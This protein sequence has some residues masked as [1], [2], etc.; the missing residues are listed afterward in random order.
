M[1]MREL[2]KLVS[3]L[4]PLLTTAASVAGE[5]P[6]SIV[7]Q[8][9]PGVSGELKAQLRRYQNAR[10]ASFSGWL[11][12]RREVLIGTRFAD[13]N[14]V[15]RVAFPG[16]ARAQ[17]TFLDDRVVT[18]EP[19]PV[20]PAFAFGAD[21]GG[22]ENYQIFVQDARAGAPT[23]L[24]DGTSRNVLAGWS[25]SG[26][27]L[28]WSSNA[29]NG[30]DMDL[31]VAE[32]AD[33]KSRRRLKEVAGTWSIAD[34]SP[35][36][37][38]VAAV[39]YISANE[40]YVSTIDVATGATRTLNPRPAPGATT[41]SYDEVRFARDGRSLFWTTDLDSEFRRLAR[42][43]LET[44]RATVLTAA[45]PWDVEGYD[46]SD[47]GRTVVLVANEDGLSRL[48]VLDAADGR[49]RPAPALPAGQINGLK[50]RKGSQEFGFTLSSARAPGDVYS[51]DLASE[52]LER[53]TASETGGLDTSQFTEPELIHYPTF[54]GRPIP[55][56]V[57]RPGPKFAGPRPVLIDIHGGP[58]GQFRPGFLGRL[59]SLIDELGVALI[60]PNV[61][62]SSGY[63]KSYLKLDNGFAREDSVKDIGALLDWV[64]TQ[65]GLDASRVAVIGGSYGGFMSLSTMTHYS[66]RLKCGIDIVGISNF[67]TFLQNTQGYRRDL[68][69]AEYGDERDP[70]MRAHLER[71]S[72][73]TSAARITVPV[74]VVQGQND[75]R[76]PVTEA[77]QIVAAIRGQG[78]PVWYVVAKDEGHGFAKKV[79]Q[80]YL[81][82]AEVLFLRQ[83]L[84]GDRP[85]S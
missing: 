72:P 40:S 44:G 46:L 38:Q 25:N 75:P 84:L 5:V 30:K 60:F 61:R 24:T 85:P 17:L 76:V 78:R 34:W 22:A 48:H 15:H 35:D 80:D 7:A 13:T 52:R 79:N 37:R 54:D 18:A 3:A 36:D 1:A 55:A 16:G 12:G 14:Q 81:Q 66:D 28:G 8:G 23:R 4:M 82:A 20:A 47:D 33:P 11:G 64:K 32:P 67:V 73:L 26:R 53:W 56:F 45:I 9:V 68:R 59:N 74:L 83:Y 51:Y 6:D 10:S 31:Y 42:Y 50:F 65:P 19:S 2:V 29:R 27:V 57:Y 41:V 21:E 70:T 49:E 71:I 62:G 58:E 39:E 77:E 63:G 69:R 43:D